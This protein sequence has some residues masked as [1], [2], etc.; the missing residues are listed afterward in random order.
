MKKVSVDDKVEEKAALRQRAEERVE[1][2]QNES[3]ANGLDHERQRM[4]HELEVYQIELEMQNDE[5]RATRREL[6]AGLARYTELFD[7]AP[8]GYATLDEQEVIRAINLA[9]AR[10]LG[11]NRKELVGKT[12]GF[13]LNVDQHVLFRALLNKARQSETTE[14]AELIM[15]EVQAT[16]LYLNISASVLSNPDRRIL[17]AFE[18]ITERTL[19]QE[20]LI[21]TEQALCDA[22]MRTNEFLATLSHELRNPLAPIRNS[23]FLLKRVAPG[24]D[25]AQTAQTVIERQVTH[26]TRLVD[27][28]LDMTRIVRGK[29]QLQREVL[30]LGPLVSSTVEDYRL[31]FDRS[32]IV[33]A[34]RCDPEPFFVDADAA[35]LIQVVTNLLG[36]AEKFTPRGGRVDVTLQRAGAKVVLNVRDTGVGI[37]A[38]VMGSLFEP[39]AQAPQ[40]M[41]RSRGGLGLGLA[42]VKGLVELHGGTVTISSPGLGE[43]TLVSVM[44]P[45]VEVSTAI[46]ATAHAPQASNRRVL[47]IEDN[48]DAAETLRDALEL[49]GHVVE[50]AY[51]GPSGIEAALRFLPDVVI[52]DIGLPQMDGYQVAQVLRAKPELERTYLVAMSGYAAPDD[53]DRAQKAG[54]DKH[55]AKPFTM[56]DINRVLCDA[57][58]A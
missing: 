56:D 43:G 1:K 22:N 20:R 47:V 50:V 5:L 49:C 48:D 17:L 11:R 16:P 2:R 10:L 23:L 25:K 30:D 44:L 4:S 8:L 31:N 24:S 9:G 45:L 33:V 29:V 54:F 40:T 13:F 37:T 58:L 55:L 38:D 3:P 18:D 51:D 7:F 26:L 19:R 32:G 39:F 12:F 35:R 15:H 6:E 41:E 53:V 14:S 28:L 52:C 34:H 46:V 42:T 27:D 36:N 21:A 57:R